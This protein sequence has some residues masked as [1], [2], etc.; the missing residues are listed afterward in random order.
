VHRAKRLIASSR[1]GLRSLRSLCQT[2]AEIQTGNKKATSFAL[3]R[4]GR[5]VALYVD[6]S[7]KVRPESASGPQKAAHYSYF[8][9][10]IKKDKQ[11]KKLVTYHY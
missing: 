3:I 7:V 8:L 4:E 2:C 5:A 9:Q 6:Q 11:A 10:G 1:T